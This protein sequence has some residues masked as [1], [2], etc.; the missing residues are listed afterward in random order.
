[1]ISGLALAQYP[2]CIDVQE[3]GWCL[4]ATTSLFW[5]TSWL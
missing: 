3:L 1:V 5:L 2:T 4:N